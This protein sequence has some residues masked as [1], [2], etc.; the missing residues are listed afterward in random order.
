ML[1]WRR[2]NLVSDLFWKKH[3]LFFG[4]YTLVLLTCGLPPLSFVMST[5]TNGCSAFTIIC[6]ACWKKCPIAALK[7]GGWM[8][9]RTVQNPPD[10]ASPPASPHSAA[11]WV[12]SL[13]WA[14][15]S[16]R[17]R[18]E[19]SAQLWGLGGSSVPAQEDWLI[20]GLRTDAF[21]AVSPHPGT[22]WECSWVCGVT[23]VDFNLT[24]DLC[25]LCRQL[26]AAWEGCSPL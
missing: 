17:W 23:Q 1:F 8:G 2:I 11:R 20:I 3:E 16:S 6:T 24:T 12:P 5:H 4:Q 10:H 7:S 18:G 22:P 15:A 26:G 14:S 19:D 9:R 13:L 25:S 21:R